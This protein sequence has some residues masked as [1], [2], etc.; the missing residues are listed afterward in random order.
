MRFPS[1][2]CQLALPV[3]GSIKEQGNDHVAAAVAL[4]CVKSFSS[5]LCL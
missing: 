3:S 2:V 1:F 5:I 4:K